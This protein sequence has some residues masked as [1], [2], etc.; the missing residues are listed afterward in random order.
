ME[1]GS[2]GKRETKI[3]VRPGMQ[4]TIKSKK[5][6]TQDQSLGKVGINYQNTTLIADIKYRDIDT[7]MKALYI[8]SRSRG[9]ITT[10]LN[11]AGRAYTS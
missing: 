4:A 8:R 5:T 9:S 2:F 7:G 1:I 10:K 11:Y 6:S 3:G